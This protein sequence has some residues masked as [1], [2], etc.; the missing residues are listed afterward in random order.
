MASWFETAFATGTVALSLT[1]HGE[2]VTYT[3]SGGSP[4]TIKA[5]IERESREGVY[6]GEDENMNNTI[7]IHI[8][9]RNNTEGQVTVKEM[10][11]SQAPDTVAFDGKTWTVLRELTPTLAGMHSLLVFDQG[12]A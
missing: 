8:S 4:K 1:L 9:A 3:P 10:K 5:I 2:D 7:M 6:G 12:A 11:R